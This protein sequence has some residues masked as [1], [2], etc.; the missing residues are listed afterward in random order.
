LEISE[1]WRRNSWRHSF[2]G[3]REGIFFEGRSGRMQIGRRSRETGNGHG[4]EEE[5]VTPA[6]KNCGVNVFKES[7]EEGGFWRNE[8]REE[9]REWKI[10]CDFGDG[11][12]RRRLW[13]FVGSM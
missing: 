4:N 10:M 12:G 11:N 3:G 7:W 8:G 6:Q 5:K 13:L 2:G 1:I 9:G